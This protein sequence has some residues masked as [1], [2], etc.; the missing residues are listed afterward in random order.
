MVKELF[1]LLTLLAGI[2]FFVSG[3]LITYSDRFFRLWYG[4]LRGDQF[5]KGMPSKSSTRLYS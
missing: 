4:K 5:E 3:L 2:S 1:L